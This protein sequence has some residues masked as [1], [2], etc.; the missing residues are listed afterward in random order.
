MKNLVLSAAVAL[1]AMFIVAAPANAAEAKAADC[2]KKKSCFSFFACKKKCKTVEV[3]R[4]CFTKTVCVC[5]CPK[6]IDYVEVT[7]C[8]T[9][10]DGSTKNWIKTYRL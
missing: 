10:C 4:R 3:C 1:T 5:G 2:A 8:T 7:Y 9:Y 6:C